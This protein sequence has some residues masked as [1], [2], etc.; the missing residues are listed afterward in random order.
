MQFDPAELDPQLA[1]KLMASL[2]VPRPIGWTSTIDANG[3]D[4]LA[5][6][7]FFMMITSTPPHIALSIGAR[8]GEEKDTLQNIRANGELVINT[9]SAALGP[10]MAIT[11]AEWPQEIDE[12]DASSLT[13]VPSEVVQPRRVA[14]APANLECVVR[15]VFPVG[16]LPY[17]AHLVIAEV[18]RI[19]IRD[20]LLIANNRI[21]LQRL[22]A[23]GRLTGDWY[24][25]TADQYE[26]HRPAIDA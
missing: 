1:Y 4:N 13:A 21:D 2:V 16:G 19:H 11:A 25:P 10:Q 17:G 3:K 5:P 24:C 9:V 23:L 14:E 26:I 6:F 12:F 8:D 22:D 7:S 15:Q 20:D 18:V